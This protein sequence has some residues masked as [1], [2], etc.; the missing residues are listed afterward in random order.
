MRNRQIDH[1]LEFDWGRA[2]EDYAKYRDIYPERFFQEI[3][4]L[5]LC[6]RGRNV[7]DLGTGPGVLPRHLSRFGAHFTGVDISENQIGQARRLTKEAGLDIDYVVSPA[8]SVAFPDHTFDAVLAC[9]CFMYFDKT[10]IFK[11]VHR[12]LKDNG[13]FCILFMAWLPGESEIARRSEELVL[14]YNPQWTGAHMKRVMPQMPEEAEG[15]FAV[16]QAGGFDLDLTFTRDSWNGR[17]R[18]CR[19][20]GASSLPEE[21][22]ARFEEEHLAFLAGVPE[23][24]VIPHYATVLNLRRLFVPEGEGS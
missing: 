23:P 10:K 14:K 19:G 11:K 22:I 9:Q 18:A 4:G 24:F 5:G 1:G 7:L 3:R 17:I 21:E 20:I 12:L 8:E 15:L 6:E 16:E 13:H 2:S